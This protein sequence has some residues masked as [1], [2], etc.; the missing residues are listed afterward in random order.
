[1]KTNVIIVRPQQGERRLSEFKNH[2]FKYKKYR[3]PYVFALYVDSETL[4]FKYEFF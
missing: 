1:M 4:N 3:F 2:K